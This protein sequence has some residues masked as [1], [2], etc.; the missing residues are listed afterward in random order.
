MYAGT[1]IINQIQS[2]TLSLIECIQ[3]VAIQH[4]KRHG[5]FFISY[6]MK[7]FVVFVAAS[8]EIKGE[9]CYCRK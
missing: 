1:S 7:A 6:K 9:M 4:F 8:G 3:S 5:L 2:I